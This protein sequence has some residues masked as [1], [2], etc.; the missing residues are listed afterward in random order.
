MSVTRRP[1]AGKSVATGRRITG[2][3]TPLPTMSLTYQINQ[4][5]VRLA[6]QVPRHAVRKFV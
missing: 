5:V 6:W 3:I 1:M 2:L 4:R